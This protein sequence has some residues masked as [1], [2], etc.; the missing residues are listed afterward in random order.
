[1]TDEQTDRLVAAVERLVEIEAETLDIRRRGEARMKEQ[2]DR[3][4]RG[5]PPQGVQ[6]MRAQMDQRMREQPV[7]PVM[8]R[9]TEALE[10]IAE[11]LTNR[12]RPAT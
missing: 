10:K 5:E 1:V 9:H 2:F 12:E 6:A 4:A 8:V 7:P 11:A 3:M